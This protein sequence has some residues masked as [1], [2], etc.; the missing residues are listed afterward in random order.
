M[1]VEAVTDIR[2]LNLVVIE[3]DFADREKP[4]EASQLFTFIMSNS[5]LTVFLAKLINFSRLLRRFLQ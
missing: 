3:S 5:F 1:L 2:P 4:L